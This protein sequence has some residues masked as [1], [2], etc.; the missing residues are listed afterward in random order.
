MDSFECKRCGE[1]CRIEGQVRVDDS[2]VRRLA[3]FLNES[4]HG[5]IQKYTRLASDRQGLALT[6][7]PGGACVF[8]ENN[9]CRVNEVKP[10]Q[11][12]EFPHRW[13]NPD[14]ERHCLGARPEGPPVRAA[15]TA[16]GW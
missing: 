13:Q 3:L 5:F 10:R 15:S 9:Q 2:E 14:W 6:D 1:C 4:E 7:Q 12:R 16:D 8:L 11:C